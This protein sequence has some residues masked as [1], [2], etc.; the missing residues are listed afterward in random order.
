[1][2]YNIQHVTKHPIPPHEKQTLHLI[3]QIKQWKIMKNEVE[4]QMKKMTDKK[5]RFAIVD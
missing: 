5:G 4:G 2:H 3:N 1:M